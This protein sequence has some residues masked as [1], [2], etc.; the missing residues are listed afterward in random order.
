[1]GRL[2][3]AILAAM[4]MKLRIQAR[5]AIRCGFVSVASRWGTVGVSSM[6]GFPGV[7]NIRL[8]V[9]HSSPFIQQG[10]SMNV[11]AYDNVSV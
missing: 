7:G 11:S 1:M 2:V 3:M 5:E 10:G 6:T 8:S 4:P 9:D